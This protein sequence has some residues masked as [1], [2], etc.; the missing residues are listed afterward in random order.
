VALREH[1]DVLDL[2]LRDSLEIYS[3]DTGAWTTQLVD[4]IAVLSYDGDVH[5]LRLPGLRSLPGFEVLISSFLLM[6]R[7]PPERESSSPQPGPSSPTKRSHPSHRHTQD[8]VII[9]TSDSDSDAMSVGRAKCK[10]HKS[11]L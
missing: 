4:D 1:A 6:Q 9:I 10:K 11:T 8:D 3:R 7:P 2:K 5:M